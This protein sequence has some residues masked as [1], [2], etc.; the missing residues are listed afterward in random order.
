M[1]RILFKWA[2][3]PTTVVCDY[4]YHAVVEFCESIKRCSTDANGMG[5]NQK[6]KYTLASNRIK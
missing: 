6:Q 5:R 3:R 2:V 4:A 1:F